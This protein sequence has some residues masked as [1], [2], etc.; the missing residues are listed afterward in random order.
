MRRFR[1]D[2][3][4]S[5]VLGFTIAIVLFSVSFYYVI[6]QSVG[7]EAD[8]SVP[9]AANFNAMASS[10]AGRIMDPGEGWYVGDP[11]LVPPVLSPETVGVSG[12]LGLGDEG[13]SFE[14]TDARRANNLSYAKFQDLNAALM[15]ADPANGHLDYEE[16]RASLDLDERNVDF[17]LRS[18]PVLA[19]VR[20]LLANGYKDEYL[21]PLYLGNYQETATSTI[22]RPTISVT[23]AFTTDANFGYLKVTIT[24]TGTIASG[25]TVDFNVQLERSSIAFSENSYTIAANGGSETVIGTLRKSRDWSWGTATP[26]FTYGVSDALGQLAS[27]SQNMPTS[28]DPMNNPSPNVN[29]VITGLSMDRRIYEEPFSNSNK[30]PKA[31]FTGHQGDGREL[32]SF[33]NNVNDVEMRIT[34]TDGTQVALIAN[35]SSNEDLQAELAAAGTGRFLAQL[36][37]PTF[38]SGVLQNEVQFEI[39]ANGANLCRIDVGD[40]EPAPEVPVEAAFVDR[41]FENFDLN[42]NASNFHHATLPY[43]AAVGGDVFPDIKCAMNEDLPEALLNPDGTVSDRFTTIIVGSNVDHNAMTSAAAK[44]TIRDWVYAG[45][46]LIVFGSDDQSVQWLQPIFHSALEGGS[47][48]LFAPDA[49][50]PALNVPNQ[51]D[52]STYNEVNRWSFNAGSEDYFTHVVMS[53]TEQDPLDALG[54]SNSAAFGTGKVILSAWR[55]YDLVPA[56]EQAATCGT[57]LTAQCQGLALVHNLVVVSYRNLYLD[58][59]PQLP[60]TSSNG[61]Q[62]RIVS[63]YHPDLE[64]LITVTLQIYVF[65]G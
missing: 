51:L 34:K 40:Y 19:S 52:Y 38:A 33:G 25:F 18:A 26:K 16:A 21:R 17:H 60:L 10:L 13:C 55:P 5:A 47:G 58:Y 53:G 57:P 6:N 41:L 1:R 3:G 2:D 42:A 50:H 12:R 39:L 54:I 9:E 59:G 35:P 31:R 46:T 15:R 24:N 61:V 32:N 37:V 44:S 48:G 36:W 49:D 7:R 11:C 56:S 4:V 64:V 27:G 20:E 8:T 22:Q 63:V 43:D 45:G 62:T 28:T 30:W 14:A 29:N 65:E 23:S